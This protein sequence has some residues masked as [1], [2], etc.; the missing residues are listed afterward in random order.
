MPMKYRADIDGLRAL[1]V[2]PVVFFHGGFSAFSG[3]F[4]GVDIFFVI[5][6]FLITTI[7]LNDLENNK[8]SVRDFYERRI[9]RIIPALYTVCFVSLVFA[10]LVFLPN[11]FEY[12]GKSL[13]ATIGFVS[14]I[15]FWSETGYFDASSE[16]KPLLHTWSL[17]V[18][19]QFYVFF[20]LCLLLIHR[21][22][23]KRFFVLL[24]AVLVLSFVVSVWGAYNKPSATFYWAPT[25]AWELLIGSVLALGVFPKPQN[26][27]L[28]N[29]GGAA[30]LVLIAYAIAF[31]DYDTAFP[32]VNALYP[33]LGVA[34]LLY[35][36][37]NEQSYVRKA[38]SWKPFVFIGLSLIHI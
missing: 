3:G 35:F 13:A 7:I 38:L 29:I 10:A 9:R 36:N 11:E 2:L 32:G 20:P 17:A 19:E 8:F 34:L 12:F 4:V 31:F 6:G 33:C 28:S 27:L 30:G 22:L 25:R 16:L 21:Y 15:L 14:N 24:L 23:N 5:S 1:A 26:N 18:E 37:Q